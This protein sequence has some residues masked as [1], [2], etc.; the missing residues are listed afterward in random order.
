[1]SDY[2]GFKALKEAARQD[3]ES[4]KNAPLIDCPVCGTVLDVNSAGVRNCP[5]GHYRTTATTKGEAGV[6]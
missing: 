1:M 4:D 2:G 5:L 6:A 3:A